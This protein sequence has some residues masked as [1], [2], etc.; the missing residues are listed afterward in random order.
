MLG[1]LYWLQA[2]LQIIYLVPVCIAVLMGKVV[3]GRHYY[4]MYL[5]C[6]WGGLYWVQ[7]LL[8][9][10][11]LVC[12]CVWGVGVCVVGLGGGEWTTTGSTCTEVVLGVGVKH[13]ECVILGEVSQ[14]N[15]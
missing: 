11:S 15:K 14:S 6:V 5:E 4:I 9:T 12:V 1:G 2:L 10:I 13:L 7:A 3:L 8:Q